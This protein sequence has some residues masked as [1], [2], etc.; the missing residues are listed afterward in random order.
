MH[1]R[2]RA[3]FA[4]VSRRSGRRVA[5]AFLLGFIVSGV[6]GETATAPRD[7]VIVSSA[8]ERVVATPAADGGVTLE[9]AAGTVA[10]HADQLIY[11]AQF[12][13]AS[14]HVVDAVRVTSPVP[15]DVKYV[16]DSA[17]GPGSQ[18][19]F[20]VDQ[21]RT[22]GRPSELT[23]AGA[24]GVLRTAAADDYTHV[25]WL[26]DAPLDVGASGTVRFRAVPR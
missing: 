17:T 18:V 26:L 13:N 22:F 2:A 15:A 10:S 9:V 5:G 7:G 16:A 25:R 6:A 12:T 11:S 1:R 8:L 21:G 19:L 20:S 14:A 3:A 24:D 4:A 23:L